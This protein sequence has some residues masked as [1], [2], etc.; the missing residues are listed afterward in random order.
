MCVRG[1]DLLLLLLLTRAMI[2]LCENIIF[3]I[4]LTVFIMGFGSSRALAGE[5][6]YLST[7]Q[8]S[9][10]T[11]EHVCSKHNPKHTH[12]LSSPC[13][14]YS[15]VTSYSLIYSAT[16]TLP[17]NHIQSRTDPAPIPPRLLSRGRQPERTTR[18]TSPNHQQPPVNVA[19]V[20]LSRS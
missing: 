9:M 14:F 6:I 11:P 8:Y 5:Y 10:Y 18:R 16:L 15:P 13:F 1:T 12:N 17:F 3:Y 4:A 7:G 19:L 2:F 20:V